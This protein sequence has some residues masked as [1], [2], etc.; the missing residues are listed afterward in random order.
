MIDSISKL[1]LTHGLVP[2]SNEWYY[3][4]LEIEPLIVQDG[5]ITYKVEIPYV[6]NDVY[7][8]YT[9]RTYEV[10]L[11]DSGITAR[12]IVHP[13]IAATEWYWFVPRQCMG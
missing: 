8:R 11:N 5:S 13:D 12:V 2:L 1:A 6:G 9:I 10:P 4:N 3:Q 7:S